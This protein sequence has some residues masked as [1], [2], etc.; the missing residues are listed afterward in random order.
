VG[1]SGVAGRGRALGESFGCK[2]KG[3]EGEGKRRGGLAE[4]TQEGK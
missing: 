3:I 1:S 4:E 2:K